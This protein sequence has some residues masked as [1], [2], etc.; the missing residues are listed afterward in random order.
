MAGACSPSPLSWKSSRT[1]P[2]VTTFWRVKRASPTSL[3]SPKTIFRRKAGFELGRPPV[4]EQG[5]TGLLSWTGTMFEYLMPALWMRL[6][7]NTL[8]QRAAETAVRAQRAYAASKRATCWGIS[9]SSSSKLDASGNYHYFA[10]GV[11]QLAIHKPEQDGLVISPYSTFLALDIDPVAATRNLRKMQRK[12][13]LGAY[14]FY[15]ALD[16]SRAQSRGFRSRPLL[17]GSSPGHEP[18]LNCKFP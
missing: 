6:Y 1:I 10:F 5:M 15:E 18:A 14:G 7:P 12:R 2:L 17:D 13:W 4:Q 11:P 3:P 8:L 16:F 9:E